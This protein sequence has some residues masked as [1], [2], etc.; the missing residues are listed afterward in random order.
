MEGPIMTVQGWN[1]PWGAA[2]ALRFQGHSSATWNLAYLNDPE[3]DAM[4][5]GTE[6]TTSIAEQQ[7]LAKEVDMFLIEGHHYVW[8]PKAPAYTVS[9]AVG[10]RL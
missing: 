1:S 10:Q 2:G 4:I 8:G 6:T 3:I 9:P 7:R 5:E